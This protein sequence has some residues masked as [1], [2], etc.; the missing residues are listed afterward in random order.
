M[1]ITWSFSS[2]AIGQRGLGIVELMVGMVIGLIGV[3]VIFQVFAVSEGYKRTTTSGGDAQQN[4]TYA[5][6]AL[7][8]Q[9]RV[10]GS[11][12]ARVPN[13]WGCKIIS[14]VGANALPAAAAF[15]APFAAIPQ[16]VRLAPC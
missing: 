9:L 12:L 1:V 14:S 4:G 7:E 2:L 11:G 5:I 8:R 10:A 3:I 13:M 15:P 16:A 6:Y